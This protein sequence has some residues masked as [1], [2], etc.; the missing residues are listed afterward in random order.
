VQN[1][2]GIL[3]L[4]RVHCLNAQHVYVVRIMWDDFHMLTQ[5]MLYH[6]L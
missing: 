6:K 1:L 3:A 5:T 4:C 2:V